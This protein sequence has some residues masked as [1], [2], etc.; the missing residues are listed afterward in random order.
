MLYY[1][2]IYLLIIYSK[3]V[4]LYILYSIYYIIN[5]IILNKIV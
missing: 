4:L 2:L 1:I 5:S 3:R